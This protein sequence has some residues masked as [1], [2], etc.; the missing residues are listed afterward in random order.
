MKTPLVLLA[1]LYSSGFLFTFSAHAAVTVLDNNGWKV[2]LGGFLET[3]F[4]HDSTRSLTEI[5]QNGAI[6]R[7]D[8]LN[9]QSGRTQFSIRN[10]RLSFNVEAPEAE[11]WKARG[12]YEMDFLGF[13]PSRGHP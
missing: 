3:D 7:P 8:A 5:G 2:S 9:G 11:G 4:I 10:S 1:L 12:Y 13:D 6:A